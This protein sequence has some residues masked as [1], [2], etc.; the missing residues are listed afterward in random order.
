MLTI[1]EPN[2]GDHFHLG[3]LPVARAEV[4]IR[5]AE[6]QPWHAGGAQVLVDDEAL[7]TA[8]AVC[9]GVLAAQLPGWDS[10]AALVTDGA[11]LV[12]DEARIRAGLLHSTTVD[13]DLLEAE[14][15]DE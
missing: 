7:A 5:T 13:F 4:E 8:C 10:V 11:Q 1:S 6:D 2:R 14:D 9:D 15:D 3:E 12:A